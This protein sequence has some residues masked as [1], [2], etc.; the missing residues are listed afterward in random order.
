[1]KV[2][3]LEDKI[4]AIEGI[5]VIFRASENQ[6]VGEYA[7]QKAANENWTINEWISGRFTDDQKKLPIV[8]LN[9]RAQQPQRNTRLATV[10]DSYR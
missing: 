7:F 6:E 2:G 9:G 3:D 4:F 8:V 5:R 10:R 1:M